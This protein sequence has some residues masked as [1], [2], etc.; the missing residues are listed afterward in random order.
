MRPASRLLP[1]GEAFFESNGQTVKT[2]RGDEETRGVSL[3]LEGRVAAKRP[4]G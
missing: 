1:V 2:G 3:P 4:G